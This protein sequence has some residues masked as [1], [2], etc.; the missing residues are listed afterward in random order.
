MQ[1]SYNDFKYDQLK[2]IGD[3]EILDND[4]EKKDFFEELDKIDQVE[5]NP[6]G[7]I[8]SPPTPSGSTGSTENIKNSEISQKK[9]GDKTVKIKNNPTP[10]ENKKKTNENSISR[11]DKAYPTPKEKEKK[12][13]EDSIE[14]KKE[15]ISQNNVKSNEKNMN[16]SGHKE[17]KEP[18]NILIGKD[19]RY[20]NYKY[21]L[22]FFRQFNRR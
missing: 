16:L 6:T 9:I 19:S 8:E 12:M 20:S 2:E 21:N 7:K 5:N 22:F 10:K 15:T 11:K 4:P 1:D 18:F 14:K 13:N 17:P 3:G